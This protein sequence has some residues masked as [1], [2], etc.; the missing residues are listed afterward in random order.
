MA[1]GGL[2]SSAYIH[3]LIFQ[4]TFFCMLQSCK[5]HLSKGNIRQCIKYLFSNLI[6][7]ILLHVK[8]LCIEQNNYSN[9]WPDAQIMKGEV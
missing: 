9:G 7:F 4:H 1:V 8:L 6:V 2:I 3:F 5:C